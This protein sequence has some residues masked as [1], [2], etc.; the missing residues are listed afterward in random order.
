MRW[1]S[2]RLTAPPVYQRPPWTPR[3]L[4]LQTDPGQVKKLRVFLGKPI[5]WP[6]MGFGH[7][8]PAD[9]GQDDPLMGQAAGIRGRL[10]VTITENRHQVAPSG[11]RVDGLNGRADRELTPHT[12]A[13]SPFFSK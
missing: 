10:P 1:F 5:R 13:Q 12:D 9:R 4:N 11:T 2:W 3:L 7:L 8:T 6:H